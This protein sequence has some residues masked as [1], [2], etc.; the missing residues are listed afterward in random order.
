VSGYEYDETQYV[1]Q[2][3]EPEPPTAE[4]AALEAFNA[5][6]IHSTVVAAELAAQRKLEEYQ[7]QTEQARTEDFF[8]NVDLRVSAAEDRMRR[9][10]GDWDEYKERVCDILEKNGDELVPQEAF[11]TAT[12][13]ERGFEV[14][15]RL[16]KSIEADMAPNRRF[17]EIM[18]VGGPKARDILS[19]EDAASFAEKAQARLNS[20]KQ[21]NRR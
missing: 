7:Q 2:F 15:Y 10:F 11:L 4:E 20:W 13:I 12:G 8:A 9:R 18:S 21:Q 1:P 19:G 14:G 6:P 17:D 3:A 5:D 16:A